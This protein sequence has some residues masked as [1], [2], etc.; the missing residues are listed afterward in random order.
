[1]SLNKKSFQWPKSSEDG[2]YGA[3]FLHL[4][5]KIRQTAVRLPHPN[6]KKR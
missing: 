5:P 4:M 3:F 1:M 6:V 2:L